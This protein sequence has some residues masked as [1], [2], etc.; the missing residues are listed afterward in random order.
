MSD[1][2]GSTPEQPATPEESTV[3]E[4]ALIPPDDAVIPPPPPE[5][6]IPEGLL[7]PPS[8]DIP[9]ADV[10]IPPPPAD[11]LRRSDRVRPTPRILDG[12]APAA[13]AEDW[14]QPSVAPEVPTSGV[15]AGSS[16]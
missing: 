1:G 15:T 10:V 11:T 6:P 5:I 12:E 16:P 2:S 9:D 4:E 14:A 3:P 8:A 13:V 7:T